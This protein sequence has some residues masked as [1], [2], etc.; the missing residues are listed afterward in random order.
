MKEQE[1]EVTAQDILNKMLEELSD[2]DIEDIM[3]LA[4]QVSEKYLDKED[5]LYKWFHGEN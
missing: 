4:K 1:I 5:E 3:E 2:K